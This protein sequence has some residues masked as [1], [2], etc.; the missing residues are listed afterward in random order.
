M[1]LPGLQEWIHK[2]EEGVGAVW[3]KRAFVLLA[4]AGLAAAYDVREYKNF[5][6]P[7]AMDGAQVARQIAAGHGFSTKFIRP[8]S[9]K[10]IQ[11]QQGRGVKPLEGPHPDLANAPVYP[12]LLAGLMKALPFRFE[13]PESSKFE[14]FQPE[15]LI[16][17]F[18][19]ALFVALLGSL[20]G[21]GVDGT[22][23]AVFRL[24]LADDF[25]GRGDGVGCLV[26][27]GHGTAGAGA[28]GDGPLVLPDGARAGG[29]ARGRGA[30]ALRLRVAGRPGR[31]VRAAFFRG[32]PGRGGGGCVGGVGG[33]AGA[34]VLPQL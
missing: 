23:L 33:G 19:Q 17:I 28:D 32:A 31:G 16:A 12:L 25:F 34:V 21:H 8:L 1:A 3:I 2:I 22:F 20:Y 26:F 27:V 4:F 30:D 10:L 18:N 9:I 13:I 29:L 11:E 15:A 6:S 5:S 24:G 7:E 14:R